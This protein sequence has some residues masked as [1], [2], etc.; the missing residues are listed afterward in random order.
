MSNDDEL[1]TRTE[2]RVVEGPPSRWMIISATSPS[3]KALFVCRNC[4]HL[5]AAPN[6]VCWSSAYTNE[7]VGTFVETEVKLYD[8]TMRK[9]SDWVEPPI[10]ATYG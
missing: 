3:G 8:G 10:G 4:G 7:G 2:K 9:C 6:N 5:T 1:I